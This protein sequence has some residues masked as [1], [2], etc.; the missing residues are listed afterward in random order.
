MGFF[1]YGSILREILI[2]SWNLFWAGVRNRLHNYERWWQYQEEWQHFEYSLSCTRSSNNI[3]VNNRAVVSS[4]KC[5]QCE[6]FVFITFS[7][8]GLDVGL[9]DLS[10]VKKVDQHTRERTIR[11]S[12]L[13]FLYCPLCLNLLLFILLLLVCLLNLVTFPLS[14]V[15]K[16]VLILQTRIVYW[17]QNHSCSWR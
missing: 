11:L 14:L 16:L 4:S 15:D 9:F 7:L 2:L 8:Q 17:A 5:D 12:G 6:Y 1:W 13:T 10:L 3:I